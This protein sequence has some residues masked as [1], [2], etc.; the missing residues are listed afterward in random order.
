MAKC[1]AGEDTCEDSCGR[2]IVESVVRSVVDGD[3]KELASLCVYPIER[4]YPLHDIE[5]AGQMEEYFDILFDKSF[6]K[7]LESVKP[8]DWGL[9]GW[10]GYC[11]WQ[12]EM[13]VS[14]D[15]LLYSVNYSSPEEQRLFWKLVEEDMASL[16]KELRGGG[17]RPYSCYKDVTDGSV[18]RIDVKDGDV[19]KYRLARY[20]KGCKASDSPDVLMSGDVSVTGSMG[21]CF[22]EF[23]NVKGDSISFG[24]IDFSKDED[25]TMQMN[26]RN[27]GVVETHRIKKCYWLDEMR[28]RI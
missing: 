2:E 7:R 12:G 8:E 27:G 24:D 9:V 17:W 19:T 16:N 10:R 28:D 25:G 18:M 11:L 4:R 23:G 26:W 5:N 20:G 6:R 14:E 13:W 15:F 21:A 3:K 22:H 1:D